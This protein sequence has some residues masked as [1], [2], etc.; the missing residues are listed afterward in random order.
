[1]ELAE[2]I[3]SKLVEACANKQEDGEKPMMSKGIALANVSKKFHSPEEAKKRD[4][5]ALD[6]EAEQKRMRGEE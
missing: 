1:M 2:I 3:K 6:V 5:L 4:K